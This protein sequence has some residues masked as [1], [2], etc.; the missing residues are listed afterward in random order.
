MSVPEGDQCCVCWLSTIS[1]MAD[2][3]CVCWLSTISTMADQCCVCWLS[4]ISAVC[5]LSTI[6]TM[7]DQCC[8]GISI[9]CV[10]S[11][12]SASTSVNHVD[13][14]AHQC[15][16]CSSHPWMMCEVSDVLPSGPTLLLTTVLCAQWNDLVDVCVKCSR[17]CLQ[18]M[19]HGMSSWNGVAEV[20]CG[21]LQ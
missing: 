13:V 18:G 12:V 6:S 7:A 9:V 16:P 17:G 14:L 3:C 15:P 10:G 5:W 21:T 2:Q 20:C 1:T 4:T 8:V 19:S 11:A